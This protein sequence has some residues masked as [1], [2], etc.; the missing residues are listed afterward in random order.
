MAIYNRTPGVSVVE[1]DFIEVVC[2]QEGPLA[3]R[4][5]VFNDVIEDWLV[6]EC[7]WTYRKDNVTWSNQPGQS[8]VVLIHFDDVQGA[9]E[10]KLRF[11]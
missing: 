3:F 1:I 7:V 11:C 6:N 2:R 8:F 4:Y 5:H 9:I 10:F